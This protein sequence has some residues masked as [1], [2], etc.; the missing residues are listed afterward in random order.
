ME[1]NY[2]SHRILSKN[3]LI[4]HSYCFQLFILQIPSIFSHLY[5]FS[6][7]FFSFDAFS[8]DSRFFFIHFLRNFPSPINYNSYFFTWP[9]FLSI[10]FPCYFAFPISFFNFFFIQLISFFFQIIAPSTFFCSH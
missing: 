3:R 9:F 7:F 4:F 6:L 8:I 5:I 1:S 2:L 10:F